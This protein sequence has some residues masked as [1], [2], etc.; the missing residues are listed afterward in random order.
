VQIKKMQ[1]QNDELKGLINM[2]RQN[3]SWDDI[4]QACRK[5]AEKLR[6]FKPDY[7]VTTPAS[8]M[9][10]TGIVLEE[11]LLW[12]PV[13]IVHVSAP[14]IADSPYTFEPEQHVDFQ[15]VGKKWHVPRALL[16]KSEARIAIIDDTCTG[17]TV[18]FD[19]ILELLLEQGNFKREQIF[20]ACLI[21]T[22]SVLQ[23]NILDWHYFNVT[24]TTY[25]LP[26]GR[27]DEI[28]VSKRV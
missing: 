16:E 5:L 25:Y 27:A 18:Y 17:T 23:Y 2:E 8:P 24:K 19:R 4:H 3:F 6:D 10:V 9:A 22:P 15:G 7:I 28:E 12:V 11:L 26:W 14:D 13:F 21:T 1:A 20:T